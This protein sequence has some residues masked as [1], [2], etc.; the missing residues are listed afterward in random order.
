V[1][2]QLDVEIGEGK[3][4][5]LGIG[6]DGDAIDQ[7]PGRDKDAYKLVPISRPLELAN[8]RPPSRKDG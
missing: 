4:L 3:R 5:W 8:P 7:I 1:R 6:Y 2:V